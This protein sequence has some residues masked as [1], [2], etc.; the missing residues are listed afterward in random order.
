LD[1]RRLVSGL[2]TEVEVKSRGCEAEW[3]SARLTPLPGRSTSRS[4]PR[5]G[6]TA[7]PV[8]VINKDLAAVGAALLVFVYQIR[9]DHRPNLELQAKL[10]TEWNKLPG[11]MSLISASL[12]LARPH[13]LKRTDPTWKTPPDYPIVSCLVCL[14]VAAL[15]EMHEAVRPGGWRQ[16]C[17]AIRLTPCHPMVR[18]GEANGV[19]TWGNAATGDGGGQAGMSVA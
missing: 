11:C 4:F 5:K 14:L 9:S 13:R 17:A 15:D 16:M 18:G 12:H 2:P 8:S 1:S 3:G 19:L 7:P 6:A 10:S